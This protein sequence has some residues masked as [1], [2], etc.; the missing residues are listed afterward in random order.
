MRPFEILFDSTEGSELNHPA[1]EP[2]GRLCFPQP[3]ANR[4][5]IFS[6]FVQSLDGIASLKGKHASGSHISQSREDRWLMDL[7]RVHADAILLGINT[8]IEETVLADTGSRGPVYEVDD[9]ALLELREKLGRGRQKNI[10]VTGNALLDLSEYRVFDGD[11]LDTLVITTRLGSLRLAEKKTHSHVPVIVAGE[12]K[13][14]DLPQATAILRHEY[15]IRYLLCEGGPTLNGYMSQAGL[16]DERFLTISPIEVGQ[17]IPPGQ[18]PNK[19]EQSNPPLMRPTTFAAPGFTK[20]DAP[21]WEW[22]SCRR[23]QN[24][25]FSRY[26][27]RTL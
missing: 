18:A 25:Q 14:V 6:N 2:Y 9:P 23:V 26:R 10:F 19:L 16:I 22:V 15:G 1:Y 8:L 7:L 17:M 11:R 20:E 12:D 13:F 4:P 27:R 5:W 3:P 21:W 24:H